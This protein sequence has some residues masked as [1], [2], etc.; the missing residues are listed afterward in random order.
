MDWYK[1]YVD[2]PNK[3]SKVSVSKLL[4]FIRGRYKCIEIASFNFM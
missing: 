1:E 3:L 2:L 4:V